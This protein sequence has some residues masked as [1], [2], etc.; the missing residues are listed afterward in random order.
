MNS[1]EINITQKQIYYRLIALWVVCEAFA[2]GIMHGIKIPFSGLIISSLAMLC[3]M[4]IAYN[5]SYKTAIIKATLIVAIFKFMLS[6]HS[7]GTAYIAVFF[8]GCMGQL[9]FANKKYF[10]IA[11]IIL[12]ILGAV[13]SG[14]QRL[15]VLVI[16]YGNEF[17][18]GVNQFIQKITGEKSVTNYSLVLA[19]GYI[20]IHAF[21]GLLIG[22]YGAKIAKN[23]VQWKS[24]YPNLILNNK[25]DY[26]DGPNDIKQKK[27]KNWRI[28][29]LICWAILIISYFNPGT[30]SFN[31]IMLKNDIVRILVRSVFIIIT[32]LYVISPLVTKW[33]K[34]SLAH[35]RIKHQEVIATV[36]E[37]LPDVKAVFKGSWKTAAEKNGIKRWK[38]FIKTLVVNTI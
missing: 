4:L 16:V 11:A 28:V 7:P 21:V 33:L 30:F 23:A 25:D 22:I 9:L 31:K 5:I 37:L 3:I 10:S 35:K 17:W 1:M 12:G 38:L 18:K 27:R 26:K 2:G 20:I 13:E 15:L 8:Q 29:F 19:I 14:I 34:K 36:T 6:P 24:K 32:W